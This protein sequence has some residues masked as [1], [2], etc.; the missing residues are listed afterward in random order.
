MKKI[1]VVFG[2]LL[3]FFFYPLQRT[4]SPIETFQR[5]CDDL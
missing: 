5:I 3:F 2:F 1:L 4:L